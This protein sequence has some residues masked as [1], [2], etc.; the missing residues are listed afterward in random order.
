[1]SDNLT[2]F[3]GPAPEPVPEESDHRKLT[4]RQHRLLDAGLHPLTVVLSGSLRLHEEAAPAKDRQA[5]GRRCG[6][7]AFRQRSAWGYPKCTFGDG[8][9]ATRGTATDVRAFWSACVD[10]Q[11]RS[12]A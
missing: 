6:N 2:L 9:R 4:R 3:G 10:H 1:M 11:W 12:D 8:V 7:C 5:D